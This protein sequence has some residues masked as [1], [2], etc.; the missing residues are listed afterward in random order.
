MCVRAQERERE[1]REN[2]ER[3]ELLFIDDQRVN[4]KSVSTTRENWERT[5]GGKREMRR[6]VPCSRD[7]DKGMKV[8]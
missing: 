2:R 3:E 6:G 1:R 7:F 8:C 4:W 5:G